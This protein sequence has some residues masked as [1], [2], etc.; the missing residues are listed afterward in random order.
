MPQ[1]CI[2]AGSSAAFYHPTSRAASVYTSLCALRPHTCNRRQKERAVLVM[3]VTRVEPRNHT[4]S[5]PCRN[6]QNLFADNAYGTPC[7]ALRWRLL[8]SLARCCTLTKPIG[9]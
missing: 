6:G 7:R 1:R 5:S 9:A 8:H 4:N 2:I 3:E